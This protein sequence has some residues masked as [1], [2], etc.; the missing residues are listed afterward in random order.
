[1]KELMKL[2]DESSIQELQFEHEG[3]RFSL[4]KPNEVAAT[5]MQS[6]LSSH[7]YASAPAIVTPQNI[8][9]ATKL[10]SHEVEEK[11][12][13]LHQIVSP[14][15][16]TFY[17][18]SAADESPFVNKGDQVHEKTIVCILEAMKIMNELPAEVKGEIVKIMVENGQLVEFGQP[19]FLVKLD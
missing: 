14:M 7:T 6:T 5:N 4:R 16:G 9:V 8:E 10:F 19:L 15:V 17:R 12:E 1:M 11:T 3:S 13:G 2:L 18:A